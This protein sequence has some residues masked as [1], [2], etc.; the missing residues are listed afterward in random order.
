MLS[1]ERNNF[2]MFET[3]M[4]NTGMDR[5]MWQVGR[6][7]IVNE[8]AEETWF[9]QALGG[10]KVVRPLLIYV[11]V[12]LA[13]PRISV[14]TSLKKNCFAFQVIFLKFEHYHHDIMVQT[15]CR[16]YRSLSVS[17]SLAGFSSVRL[18][19]L[20]VAGELI[21]PREVSIIWA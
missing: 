8:G 6:H 20:E 18:F 19:Q 7:V 3:T 21:R 9:W 10:Q 11:D 13:M 16:L 1:T 15:Y 12:L 5:L 4:V 14:D 2:V 17:L